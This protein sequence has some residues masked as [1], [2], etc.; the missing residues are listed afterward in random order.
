MITNTHSIRIRFI[1]HSQ[2]TVSYMRDSIVSQSWNQNQAKIGQVVKNY[3]GDFLYQIQVWPEWEKLIW[4]LHHFSCVQWKRH[5]YSAATRGTFLL[6]LTTQHFLLML[7][8][9]WNQNVAR[10][11]RGR[12]CKKMVGTM[13]QSIHWFELFA[14]CSRYWGHLATRAT[15]WTSVAEQLWGCQVASASRK[16]QV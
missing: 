9:L 8:G 11:A 1:S 3:D 4:L 14:T 6:T 16:S 2:N 15:G 7:Q 12:F 10:V 13:L 5:T